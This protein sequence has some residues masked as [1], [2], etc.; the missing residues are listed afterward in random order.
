MSV[1]QAPVIQ[2]AEDAAHV[3]GDRGIVMLAVR[4]DTAV[5]LSGADG[6][7][8]PPIVDATGRLHVNAGF[9]LGAA[10][11]RYEPGSA[12][13]MSAVTYD[14]DDQVGD[15]VVFSD[16]G[17][18]GSFRL[19]N[20]TMRALTD[21]VAKDYLIFFFSANPD[22]TT[23]VDGDPLVIHANDINKVTC[24]VS[25]DGA[26][27]KSIGAG[28]SYFG[29]ATVGVDKVIG[30]TTFSWAVIVAKETITGTADKLEIAIGV[31]QNE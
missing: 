15:L 1:L 25:I 29:L 31:E 9:S 13:D 4:K 2:K 27:F 28:G 18:T 21:G 26:D 23:F 10:M 12:I 30:G 17:G 14:T 19:V 24:V 6:D 20:V 5:A 3:S 22:S 11:F 8:T 16:V 7:Y